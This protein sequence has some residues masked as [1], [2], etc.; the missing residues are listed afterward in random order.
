MFYLGIDV[1]KRTHVASL[2][3]NTGKVLYKAFS[4]SNTSEGGESLLTHL[5]K[6]VGSH[7]HLEVGMEATGHYWLSL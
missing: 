5:R 6:F 2:I 7:D 1:G 3:S 4:F